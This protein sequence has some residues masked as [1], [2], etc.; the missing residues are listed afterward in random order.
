M[1][2]VFV[3][4]GFL[5]LIIGGLMLTGCSAF[6]TR[7]D[8]K[9]EAKLEASPHYD[10]KAHKFVNRRQ[11][12]LDDN[13]KEAMS[14]STFKEWFSKGVDRSPIK[15]LPQV[16][17]DLVEFMK[18][19]D[20]IKTIWFGHSTFLLNLNGKIV[21]VDPVFSGSASPFSFMVKRFQ[22]PAL[23]LSELPPVDYVV[24]S[25]DHYDHLDMESMKFF[26]DKAATK[27]VTPLGVGSHLIGWGI[28]ANRI[29]ELDWW[30]THQ[31]SGIDFIATPAQHFSGRDGIHDNT[32]LWASWVI[33][34]DKHNIYFSGDSGY[35]THFKEIGEKYGPFDLAFIENGQY[36]IKWHA[37]HMLPE[38]SV[39]A[40]FDLKAKRYFPVHWGMF[41]LA[42]H[43]WY[44]PIMK[45]SEASKVRG[46][47]LVSPKLG[48]TIVINDHYVNKEW[49]NEMLEERKA[50]AI[51]EKVVELK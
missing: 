43:S 22:K 51:A 6:G 24:I 16:K 32:T 10:K 39:Q 1:K 21:L 12:V 19:S 3:L 13:R 28:E 41:E 31:E 14:F 46:I 11:Q 23:E 38:Q 4:A 30:Q 29:T 9:Y 17:P 26:K 49:W 47:N 34:T 35:D 36:N 44:E 48:E 42:F 50:P 15:P 7:P 5:I 8:S 45:I 40:Y 2:V 33:R 20:E 37:V 27:F 18:P 25:H